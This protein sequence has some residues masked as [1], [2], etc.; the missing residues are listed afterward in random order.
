MGQ[1]NLEQFLG[2]IGND[3]KPTAVSTDAIP[4][5]QKIAAFASGTKAP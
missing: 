2:D 4:A 3:T 5:E 1:Q